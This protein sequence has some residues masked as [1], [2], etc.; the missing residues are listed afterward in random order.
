MWTGNSNDVTNI[1]YAIGRDPDSGTR[2]TAFLETGVQNFVTGVT[3]TTVLQWEP[4]NAS[5][6]V[7]RNNPGA[8][9]GQNALAR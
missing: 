1:V 4:T 7:N 9:T 3:P 6:Q 2:K 5:G 8:I